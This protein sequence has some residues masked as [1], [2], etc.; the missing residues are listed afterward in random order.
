[1]NE[2]FSY[3]VQPFMTTALEDS[4]SADHP[5]SYQMELQN[6][7]PDDEVLYWCELEI[8]GSIYQS[9]NTVLLEKSE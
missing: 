6:F 2:E 1:M 9:Q 4:E 7:G 3:D 8:D 5:Y